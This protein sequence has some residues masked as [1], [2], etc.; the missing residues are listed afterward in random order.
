MPQ[1]IGNLLDALGVTHDPDEGDLI[2]DAVVVLKVIDTDGV[3]AL[4]T[5]HSDGMSWIER[6]GMLRVAEHIDLG[7][8]QE[9]E[10]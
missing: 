1:P 4:R 9:A 7:H 10:Q 6:I 8:I 5:T 2:T 3:V